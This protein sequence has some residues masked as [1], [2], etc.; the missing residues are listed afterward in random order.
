MAFASKIAGLDEHQAVTLSWK[1]RFSFV[2]I[3]P[4]CLAR[5]PSSRTGAR[6]TSWLGRAFFSKEA[7]SKE[8]RE[9]EGEIRRW[10]ESKSI[11]EL[12]QVDGTMI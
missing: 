10:D 1:P 2:S 12:L 9:R 8:G 3:H 11:W 6:K 4:L 5:R 7:P